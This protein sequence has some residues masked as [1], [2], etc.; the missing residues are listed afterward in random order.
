MVFSTPGDGNLHIDITYAALPLAVGGLRADG[1][2]VEVGLYLKTATVVD[3]LW[4]RRV[5]STALGFAVNKPPTVFGSVDTIL[6]PLGIELLVPFSAIGGDPALWRYVVNAGIVGEVVPEH[7]ELVPNAGFIDLAGEPRRQHRRRRRRCP[8]RSR[9]CR[10]TPT[11][12]CP[13]SQP[14]CA[15]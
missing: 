13:S 7:A 3:G 8:S 15:P 10:R 9:R 4:D 14:R 5:S 1:E 11:R 2:N 6:S 12:C